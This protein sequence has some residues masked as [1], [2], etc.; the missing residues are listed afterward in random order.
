MSEVRGEGCLHVSS[1]TLRSIGVRNPYK[2]KLE[3]VIEYA[4]CLVRVLL[5]FS[6]YD[7]DC[8][9]IR[10]IRAPELEILGPL[11]PV[12][13]KLVPQVAAA[14]SSNIAFFVPICR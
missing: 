13:S 12:V 9:T 5:P 14:A 1:Q 8:V 3:L 7:D 11:L 6:C 4:P 2:E 10:V